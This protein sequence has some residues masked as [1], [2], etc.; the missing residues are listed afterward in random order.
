MPNKYKFSHNDRLI[1][2]QYHDKVDDINEDLNTNIRDSF[3]E[4]VNTIIENIKSLVLNLG[5]PTFKNRQADKIFDEDDY[6][7]NVKEVSND[8]QNSFSNINNI[9]NILQDNFNYNRIYNQQLSK[10]V[11]NASKVLNDIGTYID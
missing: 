10:R 8:L 2:I 11:G 3:G 7:K 9:Q 6:N 5:K 1:E 4:I